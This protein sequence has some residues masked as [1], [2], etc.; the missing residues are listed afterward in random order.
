MHSQAEQES[1]LGHFSLGVGDLEVYLVVLD[2]LSRATI[3]FQEKMYPA[4]KI[5]ATPIIIIY[6]YLL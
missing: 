3:F 5:L 6:Y 4:D 2:R 1:I